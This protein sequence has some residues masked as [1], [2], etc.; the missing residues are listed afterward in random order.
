LHQA[1]MPRMLFIYVLYSSY[2]RY[3]PFHKPCGQKSWKFEV[4]NSVF[5]FR[6]C[7]YSIGNTF[8]SQAI[9]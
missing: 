4:S 5:F 3:S 9:E 8:G 1:P 2:D 6:R 7:A